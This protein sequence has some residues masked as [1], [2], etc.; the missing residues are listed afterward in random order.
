MENRSGFYKHQNSEVGSSYLNQIN[1]VERQLGDLEKVLD[2]WH[3]PDAHDARVDP[4]V[5]PADEAGEWLQ[6]LGGLLAR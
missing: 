3:G 1:V 5:G 6:I 4:H 2:G